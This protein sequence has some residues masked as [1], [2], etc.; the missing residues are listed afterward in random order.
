MDFISQFTTDIRCIKGADNAPADALSL[1]ITAVTSS[2]LDYAAI[3]ADQSGD[4]ELEKL[5]DNPALKVK[6]I[7]LPGTKV[8][9]YADVSTATIRPYLPQRHRYQA[10][11]QLHD[12]SHRGIR[13][14][15][16]LM[17]SRFIWE[18]IN[19]DVRLWTKTCTDCQASKVT[20]HTDSPP[21]TF[22]PVTER[23]DH[24]HIDLVGPLPP[25]AGHRYILTCVD[26]FT[27]WP[28]AAPIADITTDAVAHAFIATWVSRFGVSLS[29]TSDRGGQF[30]AN[31][32]NKVMTLLGI[33]R[34]RTSSYHPQAN[35]MVERFHRQ[36]KYSLMASTKRN[37]WSLA[38]L[39][40]LL[41]I[42]SS[43]KEDLHHSSAELVYGTNLRLPA[44]FWRPHLTL[45]PAASRTSPPASKVP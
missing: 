26:R 13:A 10:F 31:V 32:W 8:T 4:A 2:S 12:L 24:V 11:R 36:L 27:R 44:N 20:R 39:L 42:R 33:R 3:A 9:L 30:E 40:V 37:N 23:F 43:L 14:A 21:G 5:L 29:L 7:T 41:G 19:K 17:T 35:G 18:G 34:Y 1:N 45:P 15:Q 28:E 16:R 22:T 38:L 6:K 25:S